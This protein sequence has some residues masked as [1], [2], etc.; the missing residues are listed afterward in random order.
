MGRSIDG[1]AFPHDGMSSFV[2]QAERLLDGAEFP[3]VEK[4]VLIDKAKRFID[5]TERFI[6][7][8]ERFIDKTECFMAFI[9]R[10]FATSA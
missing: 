4:K 9:R 5:E 8:T 3:V 1:T 6:D 2:E 7:K 10:W